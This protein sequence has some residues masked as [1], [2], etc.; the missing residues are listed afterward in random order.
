[1]NAL[2]TKLIA[3][4]RDEEYAHEYM[5][6]HTNAKL[7]AQ[8]HWTRKLRGWTQSELARRA[9][10]AQERISKIESGEF[11]S[12]TMKTMRKLS[13]ALDVNLHIEFEPFSHGIVDV[14]SQTRERLE[15]PARINSLAELKR[16]S[17]VI[18]G[19]Y[20]ASPTFISGAIATAQ[21]PSG[22]TGARSAMTAAPATPL[23]MPSASTV[24]DEAMP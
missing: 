13:R 23:A 12:L 22:V 1:M 8:I 5:D 6:G 16:S 17:A 4:F 11:T 18:Q 2:Q 10:M 15:L 24:V 3:E 21:T 14:C 19:M 20:G 9:G 7:A